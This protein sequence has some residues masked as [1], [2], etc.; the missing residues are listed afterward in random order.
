VPALFAEGHYVALPTTAPTKVLAC[1]R[2]HGGTT[3]VLVAAIGTS[4]G[5]AARATVATPAHFWGGARVQVPPGRYR[6]VLTGVTVEIE[7]SA[8]SVRALSKDSPV[9]LLITP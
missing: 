7:Q 6:N 3:L 9:T 8:V 5:P 4:A 2:T 1:A